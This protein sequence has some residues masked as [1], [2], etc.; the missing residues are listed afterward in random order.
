MQMCT[1][2]VADVRVLSFREVAAI[3][4]SCSSAGTRMLCE[5]F[6]KAMIGTKRFL[7][8][9]FRGCNSTIEGGRG[10]V[11][12]KRVEVKQNYFDDISLVMFI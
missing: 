9:T 6:F 3:R 11:D 12:E 4:D 7:A 1:H 2:S 8:V 10:S 5:T